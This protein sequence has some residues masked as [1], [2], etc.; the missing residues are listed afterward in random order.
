MRIALDTVIGDPTV[1][2]F[3]LNTS[4]MMFVWPDVTMDEVV[5]FMLRVF[6]WNVVCPDDAKLELKVAYPNFANTE[7]AV[8]KNIFVMVWVPVLNISSA[9]KIS[10]E[11]I[12]IN[13]WFN[14]AV[15][16]SYC[17]FP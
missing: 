13:I 8:L 15:F 4:A 5:T 3:M 12:I 2:L 14:V 1:V 7:P 11:L 9:L 17:R 10:S 6:A 16:I